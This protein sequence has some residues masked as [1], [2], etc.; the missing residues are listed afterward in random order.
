VQ[1]LAANC[2]GISSKLDGG[3]AVNWMGTS[4]ELDGGLAVKWIFK[5]LEKI[6]F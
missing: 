2:A 4:S 1:G 5:A 3:L 6:L